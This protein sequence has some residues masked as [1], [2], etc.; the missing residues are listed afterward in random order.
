MANSSATFSLPKRDFLHSK[1]EEIIRLWARG[2][3]QGTFYLSVIDGV[4]DFQC[5]IHL[6]FSDVSV[7]EHSHQPAHQPH[8]H[9]G[10]RRRHKGP[11]QR[12]RDRLRAEVH[13][14]SHKRTTAAPAVILPFA[15]KILPV[16][17]PNQQAV[18]EVKLPAAAA[19]AAAFV[20]GDPSATPVLA[21]SAVTPPVAE[22]PAA[23]RPTKSVS[24]PTLNIDVNLAK[25]QLFPPPPRQ[26]P[27]STLQLQAA[28]NKKKCYQMKEDDLWTK[29]F[30]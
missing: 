16:K 13:H 14:S 27:P 11:A 7:P 10:P 21:A 1:L 19:P 6:D 3:G 8:H 18:T 29:L 5:G 9:C 17:A 23:V 25:K 22:Y 20:A 24:T 28:E 2:S 12:E 26:V 4:P 15:G 30:S